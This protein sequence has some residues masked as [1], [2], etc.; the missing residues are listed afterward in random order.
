M[1]QN[2]LA[3]RDISLENV[4][5]DAEGVCHVCDFGLATQHGKPLAPG[6]VGKAWYMAPE[7]FAAKEPYDPLAADMWSL[8]VLLAI[9]LAGAPLVEAHE[10]GPAVPRPEPRRGVR[11]L[12]RVF[13]RKLSEVTWDLLEKLLSMDPRKRPTLEQ[14]VEHPFLTSDLHHHTP[15]YSNCFSR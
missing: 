9:M 15:N 13:P 2:G 10:R 12:R 8:G 4:L 3:H 1:K 6:R 5:L 7:V 14:V 11:K